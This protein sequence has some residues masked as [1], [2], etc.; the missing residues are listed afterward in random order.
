MPAGKPD[1]R[2]GSSGSARNVCSVNTFWPSRGPV[3][4]RYVIEASSR[5]LIDAS[6]PESN[7]RYAFSMLRAALS[8]RSGRSGRRSAAPVGLRNRFRLVKRLY[9]VPTYAFQSYEGS[10]QTG[11]IV[12]E[13]LM[14]R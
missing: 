2:R 1:S 7:A 9:E 4:I 5:L 3:A 6:S 10:L 14:C 8:P 11:Q 13:S 12:E